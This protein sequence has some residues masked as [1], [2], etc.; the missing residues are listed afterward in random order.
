MEIK[1]SV[2]DDGTERKRNLPAFKGIGS[3]IKTKEVKNNKGNF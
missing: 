2:S 3:V 1:S